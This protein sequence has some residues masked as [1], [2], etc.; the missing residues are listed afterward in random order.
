MYNESDYEEMDFQLLVGTMEALNLYLDSGNTVPQ[1]EWT[2]LTAQWTI[3][4]GAELTDDIYFAVQTI[5]WDIEESAGISFYI[6]NVS[7]TAQGGTDE[8]PDKTTEP[9]VT[10]APYHEGD[11]HGLL[12]SYDFDGSPENTEEIFR[13]GMSVAS[14]DG[15]SGNAAKFDGM[16]GYR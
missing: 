1:G 7:I 13:G 6:D 15:I 2:T 9:A 4:E 16:D 14:D 10:D 12:Y 3:P 8:E 11:E 5:D